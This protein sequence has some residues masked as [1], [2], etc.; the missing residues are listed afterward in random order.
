MKVSTRLGREG[1][2]RVGNLCSSGM[3]AALPLSLRVCAA[4]MANAPA[5]AE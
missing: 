3:L 2:Q 4:G 1:N 5:A